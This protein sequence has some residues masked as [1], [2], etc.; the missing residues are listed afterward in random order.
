MFKPS[1]EK[2][3][4]KNEEFKKYREDLLTTIVE[5]IETNQS[6]KPLI[7]R[8]TRVSNPITGTKYRGMNTIILNEEIQ[9]KDYKDPRWVTFKQAQ[10]K[11]FYLKSDQ[12]GTTI[13]FAKQAEKEVERTNEQGKIEKV[14]EPYFLIQRYHVFNAEQFRDFPPIEKAFE[15]ESDERKAILQS[16]KDLAKKDFTINETGVGSATF[17]RESNTIILPLSETITNE[18]S[19]A[20]NFF[21]E[22]AHAVGNKTDLNKDLSYAQEEIVAELTSSLL[23]KELGFDT[24]LQGDSHS[25]NYAIGWGSQIEELKKNP[26]TL[27][28]YVNLAEKRIEF[29]KE[30]YIEKDLLKEPEL[31]KKADLFKGLEIT[32]IGNDQK[33]NLLDGAKLQ[34]E[35]AYKAL[36]KA[37]K[38]GQENI[39]LINFKNDDPENVFQSY[40]YIRFDKPSENILKE[41]SGIAIELEKTLFKDLN[42]ELSVAISEVNDEKEY[43]DLT[44][45][46]EKKADILSNEILEKFKRD[47]ALFLKK[48]PEPEITPTELFKDLEIRIIQDPYKNF[49]LKDGTKLQGEEAFELVNKAFREGTKPTRLEI[50]LNSESSID[51]VADPIE[52]GNQ[53]TLEAGLTRQF[54]YELNENRSLANERYANDEETEK[55]VRT[56]FDNKEALLK[57]SLHQ[58]REDEALFLK[59]QLEKEIRPNELS[60]DRLANFEAKLKKAEIDRPIIAKAEEI[61]FLTLGNEMESGKVN[62]SKVDFT[63]AQ[64]MLKAEIPVDI[65]SSVIDKNSQEAYRKELYGKE[66]AQSVVSMAD[67]YTPER[68]VSRDYDQTIGVELTGDNPKMI[69]INGKTE[70][71]F[72]AHDLKAVDILVNKIG[73]DKELV[74]QVIA[75][76]SRALEQ[77]FLLKYPHWQDRVD[78][79][80]RNQ[81]K[82]PDVRLKYAQEVVSSIDNSLQLS[83]TLPTLPKQPITFLKSTPD[84]SFDR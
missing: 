77:D 63:S 30:N 64:E 71:D 38:N 8:F 15:Y 75:E 2:G 31:L 19:M 81:Q 40:N 1:N 76:K 23:H 3:S 5:S 43:T 35:D 84:L 58:F 73:H 67:G 17:N 79:S 28:T 78:H 25:L 10:E 45:F 21:H 54:L 44:Q 14:K 22:L 56:T 42:D 9:E 53:K 65:A 62:W 37:V 51:I 27:M 50:R 68:A 4:N 11:G 48:Q 20:R 59:K 74:E 36:E 34:G 83:P 24:S 47:E 16:M 6:V 39:L 7:D 60:Q 41:D 32:A 29:I 26:S 80:N 18:E 72:R 61:Y 82:Y 57:E 49:D 12:S 66:Y 69:E 55:I 13:S 52:F 70:L 33:L 46:F